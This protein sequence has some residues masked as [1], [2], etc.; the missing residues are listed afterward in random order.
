MKDTPDTPAAP[1]TRFVYITGGL[2]LLIV[3]LLA[4]LWLGMRK[5][6]LTAEGT[7]LAERQRN[8]MVAQMLLKGSLSVPQLNL[9]GLET[10]PATLDGR[11]VQVLHL[12]ARLGQ[13]VGFSPG[14]VIVVEPDAE[15]TTAPAT[16]TAPAGE[17]SP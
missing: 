15:P 11:A 6:A 8:Q 4:G 10:A 16:A 17:G 2:M 3:V 12:P 13:I 1:D 9:E 7:L 14:Q 5:R